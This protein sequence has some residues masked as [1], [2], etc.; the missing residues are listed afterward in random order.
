M[1][2]CCSELKKL[3]NDFD[4]LILSSLS[5]KSNTTCCNNLKKLRK[6]FNLILIQI[7]N[8]NMMNRPKI[9]VRRS[10]RTKKVAIKFR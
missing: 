6:Y 4:Q 3:Q 9:S 10:K 1:T 5:N 8:D 7:G 2:Q